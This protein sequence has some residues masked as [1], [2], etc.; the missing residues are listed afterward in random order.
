M[1][2]IALSIPG[3]SR[4]DSP[5]TDAPHVE[6]STKGSDKAAVNA[7]ASESD[8]WAAKNAK[9]EVPGMAE[10]A[11]KEVDKETK[12][13]SDEEEKKVPNSPSPPVPASPTPSPSTP[14]PHR[15][16][17]NEMR[18]KLQ[19]R[20]DDPKT[21]RVLVDG[22]F[23]VGFT[24]DSKTIV[25]AEGKVIAVDEL[26]YNDELILRYSGKELYAIEVE[27]VG[28]APRPQ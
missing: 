15:S 18:G 22:G 11:A 26:E 21:L 2:S 19:S 13:T 6:E 8:Q 7:A 14:P 27:R 12:R 4:A 17:L 1:M 20:E 28:K 3:L 25:T 9:K 10:E 23:N 16:G 24:Y 5:K